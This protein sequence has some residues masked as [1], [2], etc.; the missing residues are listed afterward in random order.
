MAV[1]FVKRL[2]TVMFLNVFTFNPCVFIY[3]FSPFIILY[4]SPIYSSITIDFIFFLFA[5]IRA[6]QINREP[7]CSYEKILFNVCSGFLQEQMQQFW[8]CA[9]IKCGFQNVKIKL[10]IFVKPCYK[11]KQISLIMPQKVCSIHLQCSIIIEA[12]TES[13]Q[14]LL[15]HSVCV[16]VCSSWAYFSVNLALSNYMYRQRYVL[17]PAARLHKPPTVRLPAYHP[18]AG[19]EQISIV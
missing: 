18:N 13:L 8:I 5:M 2:S 15:L 7:I 3:I 10:H 19:V 12:I 9:D 11:W 16:C 4:V 14:W 1:S 6:I 17:Q